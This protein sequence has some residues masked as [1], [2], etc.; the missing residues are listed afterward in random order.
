MAN[1]DI[2]KKLNI[3]QRKFVDVFCSGET[4]FSLMESALASGY[5]GKGTLE[6]RKEKARVIG[7]YLMNEEKYP[8]V[9]AEVE[10][11]FKQ[12]QEKSEISLDQHLR[13]LASL[14]DEARDNNNFSASVKAEELRGKA[15]GLYIT[16]TE[17]TVNHVASLSLEETAMKIAE[18]QEKLKPYLENKSNIIDVQAD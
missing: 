4:N 7:S 16:K 15:S 5:G 6:E 2:N 1:T 18:L 12:A 13:E 10:R 14:R 9:R 3:R 17:T 11:R 8:H